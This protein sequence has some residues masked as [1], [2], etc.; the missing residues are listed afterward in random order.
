MPR[1]PRVSTG[2]HVDECLALALPAV[3][4]SAGVPWS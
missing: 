3:R 1:R 2:G 4:A